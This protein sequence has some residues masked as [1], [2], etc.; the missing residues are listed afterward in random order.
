MTEIFS[1][2]F[3]QKHSKVAAVR[4]VY[5]ETKNHFVSLGYNFFKPGEMIPTFF[6]S[7]TRKIPKR[8]AIFTPLSDFQ[9]YEFQVSS[10]LHR[11]LNDPPEVGVLPWS[12]H[13]LGDKVPA[14][15]GAPVTYTDYWGY[16][17]ELLRSI[18]QKLNFR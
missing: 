6:W 18:S 14:P 1:D 13:A 4:R 2:P 9:G 7:E 16:E 10:S 3:I 8:E 15:E 5:D 17:I 12:H 11:V